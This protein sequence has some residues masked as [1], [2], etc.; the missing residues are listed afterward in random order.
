[1]KNPVTID[2]GLNLFYPDTTLVF[3]KSTP[4]STRRSNRVSGQRPL[5]LPIPFTGLN[6]PAPPS[7][8]VAGE[9]VIG[10]A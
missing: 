9:E 6:Q 4:A 2:D 1:M 5:T 8:L 7:L 3:L 10:P